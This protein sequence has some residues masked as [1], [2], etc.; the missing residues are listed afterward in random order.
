[1]TTTDQTPEAGRLKPA[2]PRPWWVASGFLAVVVAGIAGLAL[3]PAQ[4]GTWDVLSALVDRSP[5]VDTDAALGARQ[6][7][8][9]RQIRLPRGGL[10]HEVER[11]R[12]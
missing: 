7:A 9:I 12:E 2:E 8:I 6:Q 1:M 3:G 4:I 11:R 10:G 5:F